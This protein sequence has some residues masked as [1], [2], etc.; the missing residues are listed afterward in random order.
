[1]GDEILLA[2]PRREDFDQLSGTAASV[3]LLLGEPRNIRDLVDM[4]ENAYG[5]AAEAI[6]PDVR[7]LVEG[8]VAGG[9]VEEV[10]PEA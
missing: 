5:V 6:A 7:R 8:L 4:L 3:W 2:P 1:V 10:G 9:S